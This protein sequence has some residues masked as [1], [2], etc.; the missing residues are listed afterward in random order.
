MLGQENSARMPGY[1]NVDLKIRRRFSIGPIGFTLNGMIYN[2]FNTEQVLYVYETT[3]R[4]DE[5]GDPEP[6]L[7]QWGN[8]SISSFYYSPQA[9]HN[10]D[11]LITPVEYKNEYMTMLRD[12]YENPTYY[13]Y[14]FRAQVGIGIEF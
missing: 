4:P 9:D 11:G 8:I 12:F 6:S 3:G 10:H 1:W 2:I 5:H 7:D 14:G 13:K